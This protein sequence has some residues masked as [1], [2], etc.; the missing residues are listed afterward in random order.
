MFYCLLA[1]ILFLSIFCRPNCAWSEVKNRQG[2]HIG[3]F[4]NQSKWTTENGMCLSI[5]K[6]VLK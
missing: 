1:L 3:A 6:I 5:S 2:F 4:C